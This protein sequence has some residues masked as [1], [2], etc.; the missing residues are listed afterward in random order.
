[1]IEQEINNL[2]GLKVQSDQEATGFFNKIRYIKSLISE[3]EKIAD[4]EILKIQQWLGKETDDLKGKI[5]FYEQEIMVYFNKRKEESPKY[6]LKTP[7]GEVKTRKQQPKYDW[8]DEALKY[9]KENKPEM[10]KTKLTETFDKTQAK[11]LFEKDAAGNIIDENG[12]LIEFLTITE[13]P[14][15]IEIKV[16]E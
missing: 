7:W 4:N 16:I 15:K 6:K 9:F 14:E 10:V 3:K 1:M 12:E 2:E 8:K 11:K 5:E 13:Q